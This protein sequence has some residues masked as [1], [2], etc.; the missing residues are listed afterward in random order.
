MTG[1]WAAFLAALFVALALLVDK[2]ISLP[3][4]LLLAGFGWELQMSHTM[5]HGPIAFAL[6]ILAGIWIRRAG[7]VAETRLSPP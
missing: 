2:T 1:S 4:A 5:P 7:R 3:P 6:L